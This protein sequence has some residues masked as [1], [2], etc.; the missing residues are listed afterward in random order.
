MRSWCDRAAGPLGVTARYGVVNMQ[1]VMVTAFGSNGLAFRFLRLRRP[2]FSAVTLDQSM[3]PNCQEREMSER[4][5]RQIGPVSERSPTGPILLRERAAAWVFGTLI[6]VAFPVILLDL[7]KNEWFVSDFWIAIPQRGLT[8]HGLFDPFNGH[9]IPIA[10][11]IFLSL[12]ELFGFHR[13]LP[14]QVWVVA[15]HLATCLLLRVIMRRSHVRPWTATLVAG[16]LVFLGSGTID[17][18]DVFQLTL[19]GSLALALVQLVCADFPEPHLHRRDVLGLLAGLAA[20]GFSNTALVILVATGAITLTK[21]GWRAAT[22]HVGIPA[23]VF[24]T[25]Y[26]LFPGQAYGH[27]IYG[28][29]R[30]KASQLFHWVTGGYRATFQGI[31]LNT[32]H[33]TSVGAVAIVLII[34]VGI[35]VA[36]RQ[37]GGMSRTSPLITPAAL[38]ACT[39]VFLLLNGATKAG[40]GPLQSANGRYV[41]LMVAMT[42]PLLAVTADRIMTRWKVAT[43]A[44]VAV[45]LLGIPGNFTALRTD[46]GTISAVTSGRAQMFAIANSP[47]AAVSEPTTMVKFHFLRPP[48]S[49]R[50]LGRERKAGRIPTEPVDPRMVPFLIS[51]LGL[52]Q[53]SESGPAKTCRKGGPYGIELN[54]TKGQRFNITVAPHNTAD[55]SLKVAT[56][57][58]KVVFLGSNGWPLQYR[59]LELDLSKSSGFKSF[60][61]GWRVRVK[62][63]QGAVV[64]CTG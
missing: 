7:A 64:V 63:D 33:L 36:A 26:L 56:T 22:F 34:V 17:I 61:T 47:I 35:V 3:A 45:L 62:S 37:V 51:S 31:A 40:I 10:M 16:L 23:V 12:R 2:S 4:E 43:P 9:A 30:S 59:P 52:Q 39:P 58:I 21:R 57:T 54:P 11:L 32:W 6:A 13:Y 55:R 48:V 19:V 42:L 60:V 50:W 41:Y 15:A 8:L 49:A 1:A 29:I 46:R 28:P 25:W 14:W 38:F 5:K 24:A 44:V 18:V 53:T 20:L 27:P